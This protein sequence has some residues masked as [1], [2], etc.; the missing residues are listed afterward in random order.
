MN[1]ALLFVI[2]FGGAEVRGFEV[3]QVD[4]EFLEGDA[5]VDH[6]DFEGVVAG[7]GDLDRGGNLA[8]LVLGVGVPVTA[9]GSAAFGDGGDHDGR[10]V[11]YGYGV[12]EVAAGDEAVD[13]RFSLAE[14]A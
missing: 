5:R 7:G 13:D 4:D 9:V 1:S 14:S 6:P 3:A 8:G 11:V 12:A 10:L 2:R